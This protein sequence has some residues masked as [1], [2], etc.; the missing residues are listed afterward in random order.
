M[1]LIVTVLGLV[2]TWIVAFVLGRYTWGGITPVFGGLVT[3]IFFHQAFR[4]KI[5]ADPPHQGILVFLGRRQKKL[6][7]EGLIYLPFRPVIFNALQVNV[8]K[9]NQDLPQLILRTP[10]KGEIR[11]SVSMTWTPGL[12]A[13]GASDE[14]KAGALIQFLNSGEE[15]RVRTILQDIIFDRMR[16]WAFSSEEGPADWEEAVGAKDDAVAIIVKAILGEVLA[17]I[18]S[19]IPTSVLLKYFSE[20]R[21]GPSRYEIKRYGRKNEQDEQAGEWE[22]L[23][24]ELEKLSEGDRQELKSQVEKRREVIQKLRQGDGYFYKESLGIT[25]NRFTLNIVNPHGK[26]AIVADAIITETSQRKADEIEIKNVLERIKE[27]MGVGLSVEAALEVVQTE[28]GK[29]VKSIQEGKLNISPE[30]RAMFEKLFPNLL[31]A[32]S[33]RA[34]QKR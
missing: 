2:L 26:T 23:E 11:V 30:T 10:D 29:V 3:L 17:P 19:T 27:L 8:V 32:I 22:K 24:E 1:R 34:R 20:P 4:K 31:A 16:I 21:L 5:Q 33:Q 15:K 14:E 7:R 18:H 25:L 28:R 12:T 6:L 13:E 9:V